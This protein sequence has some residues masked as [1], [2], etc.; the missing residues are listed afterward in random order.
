MRRQPE[1]LLEREVML[2]AG[3]VVRG[4][5]DDERAFVTQVDRQPARALEFHG[6]LRP[7]RLARAVEREQLLLTRFHLGAGC[8]HSGRGVARALPGIVALEQRNR[9]A[10]LREPPADRKTGNPCANDDDTRLVVRHR[11]FPPLALPR[12]VQWV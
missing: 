12:Q 3:A 8:E 7:Q 5:R 2:Q 4:Q 6:E 1:L 10:A 9:D 11:L